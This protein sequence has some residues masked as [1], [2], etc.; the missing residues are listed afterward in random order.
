MAPPDID[1]A[2]AATLQPIMQIAQERLHIPTET[3][4]H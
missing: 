1:M 2:Q 3:L 4:E